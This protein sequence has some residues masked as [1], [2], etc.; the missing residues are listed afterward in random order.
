MGQRASTPP[1]ERL[2]ARDP[3]RAAWLCALALGACTQPSFEPL[4]DAALGAIGP[5]S[6][7]D[8]ASAADGQVDERDGGQAPDTE[9][10]AAAADPPGIQTASAL[11]GRY[12]KRTVSFG[13][14][15]EPDGTP[16]VLRAIETSIVDI[17]QGEGGALLLTSRLCSMA[18][19]WVSQESTTLIAPRPELIAPLQ[20]TVELDS[21][22]GR[23]VGRE[24]HR[25]VGYD[26][27]REAS[28]AGQPVGALV[29]AYP[30]QVWL[31]SGQCRCTGS[32]GAPPIRPDDCRLT[33]P[34]GNDDPGITL[35][36][37]VFADSDVSISFDASSALEFMRLDPRF[38]AHQV[39]E[40][41]RNSAAC[42]GVVG[43][44]CSVGAGI[45]CGD[46]QSQ[47]RRVP[48]DTDCDTFQVNG[49]K[50]LPTIPKLAEGCDGP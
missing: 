18:S 15:R 33:N 37:H 35:V 29:P 34:D 12:V 1:Y 25:Y 4:P 32:G 46:V 27:A 7:G 24:A 39:R 14:D 16:L 26:P 22:T 2:C 36:L 45:P 43:E 42:A 10:G 19:N 11:L 17:T 6:P 20:Q 9:A 21:D 48:A 23:Y 3:T 31:A 5:A 44:L 8:A 50:D 38:G 41:V 28:C 13:R 40:R 30:D 49:G 47:W